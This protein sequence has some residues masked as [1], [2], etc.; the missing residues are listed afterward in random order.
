MQKIE[1]I[2]EHSSRNT[3]K[4]QTDVQQT[5][6]GDYNGLRQVKQSSKVNALIKNINKS[7]ITRQVYISHWVRIISIQSRQ[8]CFLEKLKLD[9]LVNSNLFH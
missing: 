9:P 4:E 8:D 2:S 3:K 6:K 1:I 7:V 5:D